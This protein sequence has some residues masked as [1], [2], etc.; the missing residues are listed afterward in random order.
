MR[1][2]KCTG[3]FAVLI[4][5]FLV[6]ASRSSAQDVPYQR[7]LNADSEPQN[8]LTYGADYQSHR[9]SKLNQVNRS[10]VANLRP[11]WIY[12]RSQLIGEFIE[13]SPIVVDGIMYVVE[14][15]STVTAL[16]A[17]TG[18]KIWSWSPVLPPVVN[19]YGL[20]ANNRGVAILDHTVYVGTIDAHLAALDA[21]TG[22]LRW[23]VEV[24]KNS[25]NH[26]IAGAPLAINGKIIIGTGGGDRSAKGFLDAYDAKT[27]KRLWRIWT[28]P[29]PGE[30]GSETWGGAQTGGGDAWGAGSY[31]PELNLLYWGTGN[32]GGNGDQR[33]GDNLYSCSLLAIDPDTGKMKWYFQFTPHDTHDYDATQPPILFDSAIG[34][35]QRKLVAMANRNGFYY[36]LDRTTG[37]FVSAT[38]FVKQNWV[39]EF[40]AKGRPIRLPTPDPTPQ[41]I[42]AYPSASG[43]TNWAAPSFDPTTKTLYVNAREMADR[44]V[45]RPANPG[46]QPGQP[47]SPATPPAGLAGGAASGDEAYGAIRAL[48]ALS[49]KMKWEYKLLTPA[50]VSTLATAGG[51]VFSGTDE[52]DF[53]ALD[54]ETGKLLWEFT[55]SGSN[56][57]DSCITY[58]VNG[59]QY[60]VATSVN[61][62]VVF[63]LP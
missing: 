38:P 61:F 20:H 57:R 2:V 46:G 44:I 4:A 17:R 14:P 55:M 34:G 9:Y 58:E 35:K 22:A 53:F 30:P 21:K 15:P 52:G 40:D 25:D 23:I 1:F 18:L 59:K 54:S 51:V 47:Q 32:P 50:W 36:L 60:V 13:A 45:P 56:P 37:E 3:Y 41:G 33:P 28:A 10:N 49:G 43:G 29:Q 24:E 6:T 31:D 5:F 12:Q 11:L 42:L 7:I 27:G 26:A 48:D 19:Y 39:K 62:Y 16:D 63:G 8:W